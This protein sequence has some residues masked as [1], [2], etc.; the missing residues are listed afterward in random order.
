[1]AVESA[2][3]RL[4]FLSD[5]EFGDEATYTLAAGGVTSGIKGIF[6]GP[7]LDVQFEN[8][9]VSD[10]RPSFLCRSADLPDGAADGDAGD[11]LAV[12]GATY[13]VI[14]LQPDAQGMTLLTLGTSS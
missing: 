8:A 12:R 13:R 6:D 9:P 11:T 1:M 4:S 10:R 14:D 5:D 7:H 2:D 3:D